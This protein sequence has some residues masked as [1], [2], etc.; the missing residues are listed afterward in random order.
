M[1]RLLSGI[2]KTHLSNSQSLNKATMKLP[3][4]AVQVPGLCE[5]PFTPL[6][7]MGLFTCVDHRMPT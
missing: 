5:A 3:D 6:T 7:G 2:T 1:K 4:V